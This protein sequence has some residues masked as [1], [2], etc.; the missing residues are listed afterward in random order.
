MDFHHKKGWFVISTQAINDYE[1]GLYTSHIWVFRLVQW[2][3][4]KNAQTT[5]E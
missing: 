2:R 3:T 1:L 4:W 5:E